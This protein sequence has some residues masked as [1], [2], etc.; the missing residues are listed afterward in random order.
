MVTRIS[1]LHLARDEVVLLP[2]AEAPITQLAL[3][4]DDCSETGRGV[5][6]SD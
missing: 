6:V 4:V 1:C 3:D 2:E 5:I